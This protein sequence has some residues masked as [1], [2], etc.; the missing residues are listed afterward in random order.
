MKNPQGY[1]APDWAYETFDG[2]TGSEDGI[3]VSVK[4]ALNE[5]IGT[6]GSRNG[7]HLPF[8]GTREWVMD[9]SSEEDWWKDDFRG[10]IESLPTG[11]ARQPQYTV[12]NPEVSPFGVK[13]IRNL[14]QIHHATFVQP[15]TWIVR[16]VS[17]DD[18]IQFDPDD[19]APVWLWTQNDTGKKLLHDKNAGVFFTEEGTIIEADIQYLINNFKEGDTLEQLSGYYAGLREYQKRGFSSLNW[20]VWPKG[21]LMR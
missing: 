1:L 15:P 17:I 19:D 9:G 12:N 16:K 6:G 20:L 5:W 3:Y 18:Y 11:R 7:Y 10:W 8:L 2:T 4:E 13:T 14:S 21:L